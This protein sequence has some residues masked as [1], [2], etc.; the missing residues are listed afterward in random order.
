MPWAAPASR[1]SPLAVPIGEPLK[2]AM[3]A[4]RLSWFLA[5]QSPSGSATGPHGYFSGM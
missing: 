2:F 3:G 1:D 4:P 5:V